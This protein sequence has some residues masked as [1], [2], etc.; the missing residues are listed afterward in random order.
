M[1]KHGE[2]GNVTIMALLFISSLALALILA[3]ES[4]CAYAQKTA[5]DNCLN[6]AR[7]ETFAPGF[8]MQIKSSDDPGALITRKVT[9]SLRQNGYEGSIEIQFYE[10]TE[11]EIE[12]RNPSIDHAENTRVLAYQVIAKQAYTNVVAPVA[13]FA[14]SFLAST[15]TASLCPYSLHKTYRPDKVAGSVWSYKVGAGS[16]EEPDVAEEP[17]ARMWQALRTTLNTALEKPTEIY[18]A[19]Q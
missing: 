8:D 11:E 13:W 16:G 17:E 6:I 2:D 18:N 3:L 10:A 7:E 14:D 12:D 19:N 4:A 9:S 15:V 1:T 5:L